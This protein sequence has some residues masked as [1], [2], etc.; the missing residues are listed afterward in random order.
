MCKQSVKTNFLIGVLGCDILKLMIRITNAKQAEGLARFFFDVGKGALLGAGGF[1]TGVFD[2]PPA[3]RYGISHWRSS[4]NIWVRKRSTILTGG[5][6]VFD[7]KLFASM[8]LLVGGIV[9]LFGALVVY[10][11]Q[12][13]KGR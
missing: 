10:F 2:I 1:S 7:A 5:M 3:T 4:Y 8:W 9:S 11:N 6:M 13:L 12:G